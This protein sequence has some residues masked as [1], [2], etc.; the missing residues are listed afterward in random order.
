MSINESDIFEENNLYILGNTLKQS[1]ESIRQEFD[2]IFDSLFK[3][4][5]NYIEEDIS[6][7]LE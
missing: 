3:N 2:S 6:K 1:I 5:E 7:D 4:D